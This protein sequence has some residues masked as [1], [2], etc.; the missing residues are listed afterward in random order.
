MLFNSYIFILLFLPVCLLGYFSL[1]RFGMKKAAMVFLLGMSLW[2]YGYNNI[3]YLA[4]IIFS[5]LA[6]FTGCKAILSLQKAKKEKTSRAVMILFVLINI[7]L[8]VYFKYMDFFISNMNSVF[9]TGFNLLHIALPLGIS[10]FTF[11]QISFIVDTYHKEIDS[12]DFIDYACFVSFFPQLIAGPIVTHDEMLPQFRDEKKKLVNMENLT[13]GFYIFS[14]GLAK[15][16]L[17]ANRFSD[18][19]SYC[20]ATINKMNTVSAAIC[21]LAYTIQIYFDF[22]GYCDMAVGIG[23]MLNIDIP[24]NFNSPYK[25][26]TITEFWERWHITLTRFFRKYIYFPLGGSR[27]GMVRTCFNIMVVFVVSGMWHGAD[28]KFVIWGAMHGVFM[29]ITRIFNKF[30][31]NLH[32]AVNWIITFLFVNV[33]WVFFRAPSIN[34]ALIVIRNFF[35]FNFSGFDSVISDTFR[36]KE[37]A[38]LA[39]M[40]RIERYWPRFIMSAYFLVSFWLMVA[41]KN[42]IEK[43]KEFKPNF[44]NAAVIIVLLVWSICSLNKVQ[45]FLYF[46]F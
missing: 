40:L 41:G 36:F 18:A 22:S 16:V 46:N 27:K 13:R 5:I 4:V 9:G 39:S 3:Y 35:S 38:K 11:Q 45:E 29:V 10:F 34:D 20:Y 17:I 21:M 24:I 44:K 28:W 26:L 43:A 37:V 7:G 6:N 2:F 25:A 15:K 8:L 42:A 31:K 14:L 23:K 1:N 30:F 32:P 12:V 33:A 19:V